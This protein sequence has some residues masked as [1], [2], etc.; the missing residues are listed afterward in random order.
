M[1]GEFARL[2]D[3]ARPLWVLNPATFHNSPLAA[4]MPAAALHSGMGVDGIAAIAAIVLA[5][6]A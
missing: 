2:I 5:R 1:A 3:L 6:Q 4:F